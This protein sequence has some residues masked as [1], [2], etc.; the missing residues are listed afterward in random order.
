[1]WQYWSAFWQ[2]LNKILHWMKVKSVMSFRSII[3]GI[4]FFV[5]CWLIFTII[6]NSLWNGTLISYYSIVNS[7]HTYSTAPIILVVLFEL[8]EKVKSN[9]MHV[10]NLFAIYHGGL[11][12]NHCC[13]GKIKTEKINWKINKNW[14]NEKN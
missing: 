7:E 10:F 1:V 2:L 4:V 9:L 3:S 11:I 12:Y 6:V 8:F 5:I 14:K 13:F